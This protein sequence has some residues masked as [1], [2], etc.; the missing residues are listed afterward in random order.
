MTQE[1]FKRRAYSE[2]VSLKRHHKSYIIYVLIPVKNTYEILLD[3][4]KK[5]ERTIISDFINNVLKF[6]N[7]VALITRDAKRKYCKHDNVST[8]RRVNALAC[9]LCCV[10]YHNK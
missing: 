1:D 8:E 6:Q 4:V 5:R 9:I 7:S 3:Q 2:P 10:H